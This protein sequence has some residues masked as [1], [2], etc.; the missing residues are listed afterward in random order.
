MN[1]LQGEQKSH[2]L[3]H[4]G[5]WLLA[6]M[7]LISVLNSCDTSSAVVVWAGWR[8]DWEMIYNYIYFHCSVF[9]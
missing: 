4:N 6:I 1:A 8:Q 7:Y 5:L 9:V 3:E 2:V